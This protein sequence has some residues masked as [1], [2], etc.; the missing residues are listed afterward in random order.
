MFVIIFLEVDRV[1]R[2]VS[3]DVSKVM[4]IQVKFISDEDQTTK[5][6]WYRCKEHPKTPKRAKPE[7]VSLVKVYA[8]HF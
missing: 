6:D 7:I 3:W 2:A 1:K 5:I 4:D 8:P